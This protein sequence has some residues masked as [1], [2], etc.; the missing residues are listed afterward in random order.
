MLFAPKSSDTEL[1]NN[2]KSGTAS[3]R[4]LATPAADPSVG[5]GTRSPAHLQTKKEIKANVIKTFNQQLG[6]L[7]PSHPESE[8]RKLVEQQVREVIVRLNVNLT[9]DHTALMIKDIQ[10]DILGYGPLEPLLAR[11]DIADI[12]VNGLNSTY[13]KVGGRNIP[14]NTPFADE[15]ELLQIA[16]RMA[17]GVGKNVDTANPI[18]DARLP[19]GSRINITLPPVAIDGPTITIRKFS[20]NRIRLDDLV[21]LKAICENGAKVLHVLGKIRCNIIVSGGTGSG[22]TTLLNCLTEAIDPSE[23]T[24]TCEDTAELMLLQDHVLRMETRTANAEGK[25]AITMEHLVRNCLR[26]TPDRIVVGE[27]RGP[28]AFDLLQAMNTGHDGSMGTLHANTPR[29]AISRLESMVMMGQPNLRS[30]V[31][32]KHIQS[33]VHIIVQTQR[34]HDGS[35]KITHITEVGNLENG[36]IT[37]QDL[38]KFEIEGDG[39]KDT[40]VGRHYSLGI[41]KP[42]CYEKAK[43][44]KVH[45]ELSAA[46]KAMPT[47]DPRG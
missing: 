2:A 28:E 34:L 21:R 3:A 42:I 40:I 39:P 33:A 45:D 6:A 44:F 1:P 22:K 30:E 37:L 32:Q 11:D 16:Q 14:A 25:G 12:M 17:S 26:Q 9:A 7:D 27:V 36:T 43:Y 18:V 23:R 5:D 38:V 35:R 20:K 15:Q 10:N 31:I 8:R 46:L 47:A 29:D 19:D 41:T 24:I 4:E 13:I